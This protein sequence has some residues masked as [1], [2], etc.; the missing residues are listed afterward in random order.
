M[1]NEFEVIEIVLGR[2]KADILRSLLEANSIPVE[3]SQ[4]SVGATTGFTV[5]PMGEVRILVTKSKVEEAK[6]LLED[7]YN[8]KLQ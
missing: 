4:E 6:A 3:L 5:G 2:P 1:T 8:G 7:F